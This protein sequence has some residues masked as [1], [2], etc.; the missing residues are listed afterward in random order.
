MPDG[1]RLSARLWLPE[2]DSGESVP[3]VLEMIPYRKRDAYRSVDDLWGA[4]LAEAGIAFARVDVRGTGD[5]EGVLLDEYSETE[6]EDG[7]ACISWLAG[8]DWCNGAVGMRGIS[9]GGINTLMVAARQPPDLKAIMPM[10][11]AD[12]RFTDDAHYIG[13]RIGKPNL[14][15]GVQFKTVLAGPPDPEV[16]G[17]AWADMWQARLAATPAVVTEWL[18]HPQFD[19]YWQRGSVCLDPAAIR[20]PVYLVAGWQDTYVNFVATLLRDLSG[21]VQ[22]LIGSWGHTYPHLARPQSVEWAEEEIGFWQT[23]LS[24]NAVDSGDKPAA[25]KLL[26]V[27]LPE[28]TARQCHPSPIPGAW[29]TLRQLPETAARFR[30]AEGSLTAEES[31]EASRSAAITRQQAIHWQE[32]EPVGFCTAEWLDRLPGEQ[33]RDDERSLRFDSQPLRDPLRLLGR[34]SLTLGE[35][36]LAGT[37]LS[38]R[39]CDVDAAGNSWLVSYGFLT[40][41]DSGTVLF[42]LAGHLFQP[43]HRLRLSISGGLWPMTWPGLDRLDLTL[44]TASCSLTLP[45]LADSEGESS[46]PVGETVRSASAPAELPLVTQVGADSYRYEVSQ[47]A[48]EY[49]VAGVETLLSGES[50]FVAE[51]GPAGTSCWHASIRRGWQ[52]AGWDCQVEAAVTLERVRAGLKVVELLRASKDGRLIFERTHEEVLAESVSAD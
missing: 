45:V 34:A 46:M 11:A 6:L 13:G 14:D 40:P 4:V 39:L 33:S 22:A 9:W 29:K 43:G 49:P 25:D 27:H 23:W 51:L 47:P 37:V 5:S 20:C 52:R 1:V 48:Y 8:R 44:D 50:A 32:S 21:P 10:A 28:Q 12:N 17:D 38:A 41:G 7:E 3:V 19:S 15:W 16:V 35:S 24:G 31:P 2:R 30:L 42:R 36:R 18:R 26:K